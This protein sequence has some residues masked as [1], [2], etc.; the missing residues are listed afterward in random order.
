MPVT[1]LYGHFYV[2]LNYSSEAVFFS[3]IT[4]FVYFFFLYFRFN[5]MQVIIDTIQT[6]NRSKQ[7]GI[8]PLISPIKN[9]NPYTAVKQPIINVIIPIASQINNSFFFI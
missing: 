8:L 7:T 4:S 3:G 2:I 5:M 1:L 9:K 6:L